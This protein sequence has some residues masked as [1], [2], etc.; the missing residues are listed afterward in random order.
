[1]RREHL[2]ADAI[3]SPCA[4]IAATRRRSPS[5][6]PTRASTSSPASCGTSW[7]GCGC[8]TACRSATWCPT[9]SCCRSSR[10]GSSTSTAPGPTPWC[11]ARCRV[12]TVSTSDRAELEK[13]LPARPRGGRR[14]RAQGPHAAGRGAAAG[15]RRHDHRLPA[16]VAGRVRLA[17]PARARLLRGRRRRR[18]AEH[19]RG[20]APEADEGAADG[21]ARAR[22]AARALRRRAR[23]SCTSRS[24]GR[25][26]QF[27]IRLD[28]QAPRARSA[29]IVKVRVQATGDG[30]ASREHHDGREH[31]RRAVP[32]RARRAWS[33]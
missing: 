27:G 31:R 32:A 17:G 26:L 1:M 28:P 9:R 4:A 7:P 10:S 22:R 25:A 6:T 5:T 8:C 13:V 20:V 12:G 11:R 2:G 16:A 18:R 23:R 3:D 33:T 14:H 29:R 30:G 19:G 24:R 21:A 15:R